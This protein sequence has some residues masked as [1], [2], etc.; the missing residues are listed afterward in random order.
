MGKRKKNFT[1]T[2]A[3]TTNILKINKIALTITEGLY[4]LSNINRLTKL[5]TLWEN[6]IVLVSFKSQSTLQMSEGEKPCKMKQRERTGVRVGMPAI[7]RITKF[8][9]V[10]KVKK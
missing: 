3:P 6:H 8:S 10:F 2:M 7:P 4:H 1:V 5:L 9:Q